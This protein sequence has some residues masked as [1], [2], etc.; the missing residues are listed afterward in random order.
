MKEGGL[1]PGDQAVDGKIVIEDQQIGV[2]SRR[3]AAL[4]AVLCQQVCRVGGEDPAGLFESD[5]LLYQGLH[6]LVEEF[7]AGVA[8]A[9]ALALLVELG[10]AAEGV[11]GQ[12]DVVDGDSVLAQDVEQLLSHGLDGL[13]GGASGDV[14]EASPSDEL[15]ALIQQ[16]GGAAHVGR[17]EVLDGHVGVIQGVEDGLKGGVS[18]SHVHGDQAGLSAE[19]SA[20]SGVGGKADQFLAGG[21]A[22]PVVGDGELY[23]DDGIEHHDVLFHG[24]GH[25]HGRISVGAGQAVGGDAFVIE[26]SG[27][28]HQVLDAPGDAV[29]AQKAQNGG[30]SV[31]GEGGEVGFGD[32]GR[33]ALLSAASGDMDVHVDVS[34]KELSSFKIQDLKAGD[35]AG[36]QMVLHGEDLFSR[37][38]Q[39]LHPDVLGSVYVCVLDKL[40]HF[41]LLVIVMHLIGVIGERLRL[42][43]G[44]ARLVKKT[45]A[46]QV[47]NITKRS[48][49]S[50]SLREPVKL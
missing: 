26:G 14:D 34:G 50:S 17:Q 5:A 24:A 12:G 16:G 35:P 46:R 20:S 23:A 22:A 47:F 36:I 39:V 27:L 30:D 28:G 11:G 3:D 48:G 44:S 2:R 32:P 43:R 45:R 9:D 13:F 38:E 33:R 37:D 1:S 40:D 18:G 19:Q 29:G 42:A 21:V 4:D 41:A 15:C 25:G 8:Q 10:L 7:G 31:G 6:G 49:F